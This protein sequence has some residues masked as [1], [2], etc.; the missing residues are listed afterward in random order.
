MKIILK[1]GYEICRKGCGKQTNNSSG[2]C[3][4]CRKSKCRTCGKEYAGNMRTNKT[5]CHNCTKKRVYNLTYA[6]VYWP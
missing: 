2:V 5:Y 1:P 3:R 4:S 6:G